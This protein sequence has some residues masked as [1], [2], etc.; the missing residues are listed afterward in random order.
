MSSVHARAY[1]ARAFFDAAWFGYEQHVIPGDFRALSHFVH[2]AG[3][4][5]GD[6]R[7]P[8]T[9]ALS[10]C[11]R[12]FRGGC[13]HGVVMERAMAL[14]DQTPESLR[15]LC[16]S[17]VDETTADDFQY[18]QCVH[19]AGHVLMMEHAEPEDAVSEC[20]VFVPAYRNACASGVFMQYMTAA[21][22]SS[23]EHH[24]AVWHESTTLP[25]DRVDTQYREAC[26]TSEGFYRHYFPG[27][28]D[29]VES[30][31]HC[32]TFDMEEAGWCRSGVDQ[33]R[34]QIRNPQ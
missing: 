21:P 16:G 33:A 20:S 5:L 10:L 3:M 11:S 13:L 15:A 22:V 34:E 12:G 8:F 24:H 2:E 6:A 1:V 28:D 9:E 18:F 29:F 17:L 30:E 27:Q 32:D 23:G 14:P 19:A 26:F 25:C 7:I 31:S 4:R